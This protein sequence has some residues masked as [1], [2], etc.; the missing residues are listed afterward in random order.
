[1]ECRIA[2]CTDLVKAKGL[3]NRHYLKLRRYGDP[4]AAAR[5]RGEPSSSDPGRTVA[6]VIGGELLHDPTPLNYGVPGCPAMVRRGVGQWDH[7]P[8][9]PAFAGTVGQGRR[10]YRVF[11]CAAHVEHLDDP[12]PM[13]DDDRAEFAQRR[14]QWAKAKARQ[15]FERVQP[16]A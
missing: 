2:G 3:C 7:C 14:E 4:E 9:T 8:R 10:R 12:R 15:P 16:I 5:G 1:M 11:A 13:T 6:A